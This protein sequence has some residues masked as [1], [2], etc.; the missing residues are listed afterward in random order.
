[1]ATYL[2]N[3]K[4]DTKTVQGQRV[5]HTRALSSGSDIISGDR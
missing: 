3:K 2:V 1:M 5:H 4:Q